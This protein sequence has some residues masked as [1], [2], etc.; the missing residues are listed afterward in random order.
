[1]EIDQ[2]RFEELK[3]SRP[4]L[5]HAL[6]IEEKY[7]IIISNY[8]ELERD[9]TNASISEMVRHHIKYKDFF[10]VRLALK[11][12]LVNLLTAVRLYTDQLSSH[13]GACI[14]SDSKPK[15]YIKALFSAEYDASFECRFMEALRNHVQHS[16]VP[17]HRIATGA[18]WT[19]L[20]DGLL[21]YSLY[22]GAQ[23]DELA[24]DD[25]FKK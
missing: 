25:S 10:D 12:R 8:L 23:K 15:G 20:N 7:E 11:I 3:A 9:A 14:P 16:G 13:V 4:I 19:D 2:A 18:K 22:F 6:A 24:Q 5:N 1:M 21:E 17:V